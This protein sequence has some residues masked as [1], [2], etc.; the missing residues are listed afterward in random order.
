MPGRRLQ[1]PRYVCLQWKEIQVHVQTWILRQVLPKR[2]RFMKASERGVEMDI[3]RE[4]R[5]EIEE[6]IRAEEEEDF[7]L[8]Y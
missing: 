2:E 6:V 5:R 1:E 7:L 3:G 8:Y 4:R